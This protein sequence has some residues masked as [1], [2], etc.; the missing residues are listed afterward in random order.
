MA[1]VTYVR[2]GEFL[3]K[4]G[5]VADAMFI[6]KTGK[7]SLLITDG[8]SQ[9]EID[10]ASTGQ[11]IGEMPLFDKKLRSAGAKAIIDSVLVQLPYKKLEDELVQMPEWVQAVLK[12][13]SEKIREA[14]NKILS[15]NKTP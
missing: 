15:D 6:V 7:I 4:Q 2:Q 13:L 3:F 1:S 10:T 11:L 5:D 14:N 12:K 9:K 8:I